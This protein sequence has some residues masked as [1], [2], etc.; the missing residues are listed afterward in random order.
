MNIYIISEGEL[1][2]GREADIKCVVANP[3]LAQH[4]QKSFQYH[5]LVITEFTVIDS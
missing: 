4:I 3:E 2:Q 5:N 1:N